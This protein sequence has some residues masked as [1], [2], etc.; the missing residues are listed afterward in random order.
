MAILAKPGGI[1]AVTVIKESPGLSSIF[2]ECEPC[3]EN[4][5]DDNL[6]RHD[7]TRQIVFGAIQVA[8]VPWAGMASDLRAATQAP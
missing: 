2:A 6:F 1:V 8:A 3:L 4:C 5:P 7:L